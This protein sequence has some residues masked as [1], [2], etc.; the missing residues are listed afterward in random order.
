MRVKRH[1]HPKPSKLA[2]AMLGQ[3][4]NRRLIVRAMRF[5]YELHP[6]KGWRCHTVR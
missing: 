3:I 6:T 4:K 1:K 5:W 2:I